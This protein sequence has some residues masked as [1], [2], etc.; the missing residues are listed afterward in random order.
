M[1]IA[2]VI[3]TINGW[4]KENRDKQFSCQRLT[5]I[6]SFTEPKMKNPSMPVGDGYRT[7]TLNNTGFTWKDI[8]PIALE[9]TKFCGPGAALEIGACYGDTTFLALENLK[10]VI[11]NDLSDEHLDILSKRVPKH[12]ASGLMIKKGA[13]PEDLEFEPGSLGSIL[14]SS[15]FHFLSGKQIE[16]GLAKIES[17]LAPGGKLFLIAETPFMGILKTFPYED[18][19][20]ELYP[21]LM[22]REEFA[23]Y[24]RFSSQVPELMNWLTIEVLQREISKLSFRIERLEYFTRPNLPPHLLWDGRESVG[25]VAIRY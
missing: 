15:V 23:A 1:P 17:W 9:W 5:N 13:F 6:D 24:S 19:K 16:A 12:L 7:P 11:A 21:G 2:K 25:L 14:S 20:D 3:S 4:A 18:K 8:A 10:T 22:S